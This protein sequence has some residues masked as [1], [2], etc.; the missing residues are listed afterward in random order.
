V[1][2]IGG[3]FNGVLNTNE[4]YDPASNTWAMMASMPTPRAGLCATWVP[5][6][7]KI[8]AIGGRTGTTPNTGTPLSANQEYDPVTN[9]WALKS[10]MPMPMMDIYACVFHPGTGLIY[11]IGGFDG[12]SQSNVVQR[13]D[14]F[15]NTWLAAGASMPTA[16]SNAIAGVC[17]GDIY[18]IGGYNGSANLSANERYNPI[19]DSWT[20][21]SAKPTPASEMAST[22]V[23][24]G[25]EIYA[26]GSGIF[27]A[28]SS[29]NERFTCAVPT[30]TPTVTPAGHDAR[31]VR[32]G[33][34]PKSVRL[35]P[36]Q[37]STDSGSIVVENQ[38]GHVDTIGVYVD[39][40]APA[41]GGCSPSGRVLQMT[42]TLA[43]NGKTNIPVPVGYSCSDPVAANGLSFTWVAAADH[44]GDDLASC[45]PGSL[46]GIP[47]FKALADDDKDASDNRPGRS[48]PRVVVQ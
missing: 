3:R 9:T 41:S 14:P 44:G 7:N 39:I 30:P 16:R 26:I 23:S 42:V 36:G 4:R 31:L 8:Y 33:G 38:S 48:G 18:V 22:I 1:Y 28:A 32:I 20:F 13:Y 24:S 47:C 11:V 29:L 43:A 35:S 46:Q 25:A 21:S 5:S 17:G 19:S 40:V 10:A 37:I 15:A 45:P 2:A 27:G 6:N 34:V 12:I